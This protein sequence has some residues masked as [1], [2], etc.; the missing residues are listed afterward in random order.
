MKEDNPLLEHN[1]KYKKNAYDNYN[2]QELYFLVHNFIVKSTH[3]SEVYPE[4]IKK[5]LTDA[6][7]YLYMYYNKITTE[8]GNGIIF[9]EDGKGIL[10]CEGYE[11]LKWQLENRKLN[12]NW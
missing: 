5:D 6:E 12:K 1:H 9:N 7:N 10:V 4:K 3:R 8:N 2:F 11:S